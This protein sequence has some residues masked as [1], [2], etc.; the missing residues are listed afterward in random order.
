MTSGDLP[1][2]QYICRACGL[3]Y[4]EAEGDPDSGLAP[5]TRYE[6]IPDDWECPL[7]GVTKTDF[8]LYEARTVTAASKAVIVTRQPCIVIIGAGIAGW[9]AAEAIRTLNETVSITM[10]TAC[11]G[12]RYHKPE[13]SVAISHGS[14]V[15]NLVQ[16]NAEDASRRLAIKLLPYTYA[17]GINAQSH[18]LRTTRGTLTYTQLILAQ[19]ARPYLPT[20]LANTNYWHMNHLNAWSQFKNALDLSPQHVAILGAGMIGCELAEDLRRAGHD[21]TLINNKPFP[22]ASLLPTLAAQHLLDA[23]SALGVRYFGNTN[24]I[25]THIDDNGKTE[26][27]FDDGY[28]LSYDQ[29]V[30]ATGLTTDTRIATRAKLDFDRGIVVDPSTLRT[31][32]SDIFALGDCVSFNGMPCRFIEPIPHQAKVI[33]SQILEKKKSSYTHTAPVIRLKTRS[34]PI[35]V[36]GI[37]VPDQQWFIVTDDANKLVMEQRDNQQTTVSLTI[38]LSKQVKAA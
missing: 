25:T 10:I 37:P 12:D 16:E 2:K 13:L 29:L 19:G 20:S 4:N 38:D 27:V 9:A 34:L 30:V 31:S 23:L 6:D 36:R 33:A 3:I 11:S 15:D 32:D 18:Q 21:V 5:G 8:E 22:L 7:C 1:W 14:D 28:K 35:V 24:V 17:V 26:L